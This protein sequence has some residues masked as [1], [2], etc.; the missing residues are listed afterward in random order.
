MIVLSHD[1]IDTVFLHSW[2]N[3]KGI[4]LEKLRPCL[5]K[6][7]K[8]FVITNTGLL[9][10]LFEDYSSFQKSG[11]SIDNFF[12]R[13]IIIAKGNKNNFKL[14]VDIIE[15]RPIFI[16]QNKDKNFLFG[17]GVSELK[18]TKAIPCPLE[19]I[20]DIYGLEGKPKNLSLFQ[21]KC[22]RTLAVFK[23]LNGKAFMDIESVC[24][25]PDI[26]VGHSDKS[27]YFIPSVN[28]IQ[29]RYFCRKYP[30]QCHHYSVREADRDKHEHSC[31]NVTIIKSKQVNSYSSLKIGNPGRFWADRRRIRVLAILKQSWQILGRSAQN[32]GFGHFETILADSGQ[33]GA[34]S[35]ILG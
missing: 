3:Y 27:Y 34:E 23:V 25:N 15:R 33:I 9:E 13:Q 2:L 28:L 35:G 14:T 26:P 8:K 20:F 11:K 32:Q 19:I 30:D 21:P 6:R 18:S 24:A 31:T 1:G 10:H 7:N 17:P 12:D 22:G 4:F 16:F 29:K 5:I